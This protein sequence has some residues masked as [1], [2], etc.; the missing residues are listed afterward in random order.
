MR[1]ENSCTS[2]RCCHYRAMS[3]AMRQHGRNLIRRSGKEQNSSRRKVKVLNAGRRVH[4]PAHLLIRASRSESQASLISSNSAYQSTPYFRT[5][6][7]FR[8][9]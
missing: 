3:R 1:S 5:N 4:Q 9:L 7:S 2:R 8:N 6:A